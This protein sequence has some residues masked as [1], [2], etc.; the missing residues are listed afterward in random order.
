MVVL[1]SYMP[2]AS[3]VRVEKKAVERREAAQNNV[4]GKASLHKSR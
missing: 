1:V 3:R 4:F 2:L